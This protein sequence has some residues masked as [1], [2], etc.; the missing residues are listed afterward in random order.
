MFDNVSK[1]FAKYTDK[2]KDIQ[3]TKR[4]IY[5]FFEDIGLRAD[6]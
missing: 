5:G 4:L 1:I 3:N 6:L 2:K